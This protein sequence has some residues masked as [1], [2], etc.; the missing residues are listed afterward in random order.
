MRYQNWELSP[1]S[2]KARARLEEGG[3][4]P[5]LSA[6][7]AA[8][9][10]R[11]P[12]QAQAMLSPKNEPLHPPE[13]LR[14]MD[15]AVARIALA[16]RRGERIAVYGDYD[17]DGIT[18]TCLLT[19]FLG[20]WGLDVVPY[21]PDRLE[22][23]YG[24]NR[25]AALHLAREGV[26]L[27]ITVDC[28]ITAVEEVAFA[29]E[30]GMDVVVTD[31]HE[32][33]QR[34]PQAAAVV[35]PCRADCPYPFSGL[36]GVGVALKLALALTPPEEREA[37]LE[38]C[39]DLA[40]VGTVADVMPMEGENRAIVARGLEI[41]ERTPRVG[42]RLLLREVGL[43]GRPLTTSLVGYTLAPRINAAGRMG[44]AALALEL[45]LTRDPV[46][47]EVLAAELCLPPVRAVQLSRLYDL[48]PRGPGKGL[49][50]VLGRGQPVPAAG[51]LRGSAGGLRRPRPGGRLHR[52]G[53]ENSRPGPAAAAGHLPGAPDGAGGCPAPGD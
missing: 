4:S 14:D 6:V 49:L 21:I 1:S 20:R 44:R 13:L 17:V 26:S 8:R 11:T 12:Q 29:G 31:H 22:E 7:L 24:L 5:L 42:L 15:K 2:Q 45:L 50:P 48:P 46:R 10:A 23:G 39:L 19:D 18:S 30:L 52:P 53:G 41:L 32:C 34:I 37:V 35:D 28:G 27:V 40:A 47:G 9:G 36:A 3:L 33:K 38:S 43:E 25:E 16:R 51:E